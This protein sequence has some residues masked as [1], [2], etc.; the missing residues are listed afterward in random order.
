MKKL[1]NIYQTQDEPNSSCL[2]ELRTIILNRDVILTESVRYGMPCFLYHKKTICC[3]WVD[4]ETRKPCIF[5][6][7]GQQLSHPQ[8]ERGATIRFRTL[9]IDPYNNIPTDLINT[10]VSEA[11]NLVRVR[12]RKSRKRKNQ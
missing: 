3:L 2:L 10:I 8:L 7:S 6:I 1:R 5:F 11:V 9:I 4:K 12:S